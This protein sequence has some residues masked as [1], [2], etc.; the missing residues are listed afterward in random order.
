M[1]KLRGA[2]T[3]EL[4]KR[5]GLKRVI[6]SEQ[7]RNTGHSARSIGNQFPNTTEN[8]SILLRKM[9]TRVVQRN[10]TT[11][12]VLHHLLLTIYRIA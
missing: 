3:I 7:S 11:N 12:N 8:T 9:S 4:R 2:P 6:C 10:E 5:E 1:K